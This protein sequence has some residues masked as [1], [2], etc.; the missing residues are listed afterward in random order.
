MK[1]SLLYFLYCIFFQQISITNNNNEIILSF[2]SYITLK[3]NR[4]GLTSILN[5]GLNIP[6]E[7][8][9]N[10]NNQSLITTQYDLN[11][12]DNIIKLVWNR[13]LITCYN[14][15]N[16]CTNI[17]EIDLSNFDSSQVEKMSSMFEGCTSLSS[18]NFINF[19]TSN[20]RT[21][22]NTFKDCKSL[23]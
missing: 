4:T 12:T 21:M 9:I 2:S 22:T 7:I 6:D 8:Y 16:G 10:G 20:V 1:K 3:I 18:I 13:Q 23:S 11:Q 17:I 5:S 14:M 15:F 19:N